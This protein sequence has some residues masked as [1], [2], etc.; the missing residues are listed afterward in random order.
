V[1]V[2]HPHTKLIEAA[3]CDVLRPLGIEQRG[4]SRLWFDDRGW[5]ATLIEF[6]PSSF[7]RGSYLNVGVQWLW[8]TVWDDLGAFMYSEGLRVPIVGRREFVEYESD[9]QFAPL[10]GK[11]AEA[12]AERTL[13]FRELFP[14]V[15][16]AAKLLAKSHEVNDDH[17]AGI[18]LGLV[19]DRRS[20]RERFERYL[21]WDES[22]EGR[23]WRGEWDD[24]RADRMRALLQR[25][26][27]REAFRAM[28]AEGIRGVRASA[29]LDPD[30]P[31]PF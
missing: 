12:A 23:R 31:L 2:K 10:A 13:H 17:H 30:V 5:F 14:S 8:D 9:E 28:V 27:D 20:A 4:R 19:G 24:A 11:L 21:A 16:A 3:A 6:Q 7:G 1:G 22:E 25:V 15:Q 29:R 18:A 26:D